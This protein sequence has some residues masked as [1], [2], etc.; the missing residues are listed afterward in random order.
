MLLPMCTAE[1]RITVRA[2]TDPPG[3]RS[4][5]LAAIRRRVDNTGDEVETCKCEAHN[6]L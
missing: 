5:L 6:L 4:A 1:V 3:S 2:F